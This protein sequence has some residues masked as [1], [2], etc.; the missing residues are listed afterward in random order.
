MASAAQAGCRCRATPACP[1][2]AALRCA[3]PAGAERGALRH[4]GEAGEPHAWAVALPAR[5]PPCAACRARR[6]LHPAL[7]PLNLFLPW[8]NLSSLL[9][10]IPPICPILPAGL[11]KVCAGTEGRVPANL[12]G[13][14]W[15]GQGTCLPVPNMHRMAPCASCFRPQPPRDTAPPLGCAA[16]LDRRATALGTLPLFGA[17]EAHPVWRGG[18]QH[19]VCGL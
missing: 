12:R 19:A 18:P 4:R 8:A 10:P 11:P 15:G 2:L 1:S 16:W 9:L 13:R 3:P 7:L 5:P 17:G 6:A 14:C